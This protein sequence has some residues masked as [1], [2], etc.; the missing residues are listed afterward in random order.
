[1][2][3]NII[4]V[5]ISLAVIAFCAYSCEQNSNLADSRGSVIKE[6]Q[7]TIVKVTLKN[8]KYGFEKD[9]AIADRKT[10]LESYGFLEDSLKAMGIK[11][12]NL[13][14]ALFISQRTRGSGVGRIDTLTIRENDTVYVV[15]KL[16]ITEPFFR[17][18]ATLYPANTYDYQY[19]I[20]DSLSLVNTSSRKNIFKPMQHKITV[21]NANPKTVITGITSLTIRED[22]KRIIIGPMV[23]YGVTN[24]GLSSFVGIGAT[25]RVISF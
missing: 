6:Q 20:Y 5:I 17:F 10:L 2:K 13:E 25:W 24:T 11:A 3:S 7:A 23:G 8:D 12:K 18:S 1:M 4:T 19:D 15:R 9:R 16:N 21:V 22:S 14:S